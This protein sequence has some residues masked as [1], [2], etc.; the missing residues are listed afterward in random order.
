MGDDSIVTN[1]NTKWIGQQLT[2]AASNT[3]RTTG[4]IHAF[5]ETN[6]TTT[7][8]VG[9]Y[10]LEFQVLNLFDNL[11]ITSLKGKALQRRHDPAGLYGGPGRR[12]QRLHLSGRQRS[13][14]ADP[15]GGLLRRRRPLRTEEAET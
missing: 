13:Y 6:W 14:P 7:Y 8:K 2:N 10:S 11:D 4:L 3:T 9:H 15:E 1:L 12:R 5:N